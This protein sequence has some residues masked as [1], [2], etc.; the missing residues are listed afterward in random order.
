M[1]DQLGCRLPGPDGFASGVAEN[2]W[3]KAG[4]ANKATS[5]SDRVIAWVTPLLGEHGS[6]AIFNVDRL[7]SSNGK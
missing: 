4:S 7:R 1:T 2:V 5:K 3:L 6:P